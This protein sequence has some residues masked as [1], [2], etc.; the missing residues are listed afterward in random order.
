MEWEEGTL[1]ALA[2]TDG[3]E[4]ED[5]SFIE[6][7]FQA[8]HKVTVSGFT[9]PANNGTM[10]VTDVTSKF[11]TVSTSLIDETASGDE[12]IIVRI[13]KTEPISITADAATN[14]FT[15]SDPGGNFGTDGFVK[16]MRFDALGMTANARTYVVK[17][18]RRPRS[19]WSAG[20]PRVRAHSVS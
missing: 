12:N 20:S 18:V 17:S 1:T 10:F 5:G 13:A 15:R 19:R 6:D 11:L 4:R 2:A 14:T 7:G 16:G 8:G 9:N 3:F